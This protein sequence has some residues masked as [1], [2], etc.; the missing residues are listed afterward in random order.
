MRA[1]YER[2][3]HLIEKELWWFVARRDM[4]KRILRS[5]GLRKDARIL[6]VGCSGGLLISELKKEGY[7]DVSGID[8][9]KEA[10]KICKSSGIKDAL[11][12]DACYT[13][14]GD[15]SFDVVIASDILEHIRDD[16]KAIAEW[17]RILKK[18]GRLIIFVPA[19]MLLY[20]SHDRA[21]RHFRRYNWPALKRLIEGS[22]FAVERHSCWNILLFFPTLMMRLMKKFLGDSGA[23]DEFIALPKKLN[24]F[25]TNLLKA[26]NR[27]IDKVGIPL[28]VSLFAIAR[29]L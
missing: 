15:S 24:R 6:D 8:L 29:K 20:G 2:K 9:S 14:M 18:G 4:I 21:N 22:G 28:G 26:E 23:G 10:I 17:R 27:L 11:V 7:Q 12:R 16:R 3:Y 5:I 1:E 19:F 25:A 13:G